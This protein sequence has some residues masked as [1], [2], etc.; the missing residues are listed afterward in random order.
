M[1]PSAESDAPVDARGESLLVVEALIP[2][3]RSQQP[4]D[5]T[6]REQVME[7]LGRA[8]PFLDRHILALD[9]PHD[10][11]PLWLFDQGREGAAPTHVERIRLRGASAT[12]NPW[13]SSGASTRPRSC[14]SAESRFAA[15]S[16][17]RSSSV[18]TSFP[19]SGKRG[20]SR[21]LERGPDHHPCRRSKGANPSSHVEQGRAGLMTVDTQVV[22][23]RILP[24]RKLVRHILLGG[25]VLLPATPSAQTHR[26]PA[27]FPFK[28]LRFNP[29][30]PTIKPKR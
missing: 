17:E 4:L 19:P 6:A 13:P 30:T 20:S 24:M 14:R 8:L 3:T 7:G 11:R 22:Y 9:S 15:P 23:N 27:S 5:G 10:G 16:V 18:E 25:L 21:G 28:S 2:A 26:G 29:T 1:D 12:A